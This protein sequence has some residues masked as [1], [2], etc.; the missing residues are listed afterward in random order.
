MTQAVP[1]REY[2]EQRQADEALDRARGHVQELRRQWEQGG[3][4]GDALPLLDQLEADLNTLRPQH[5]GAFSAADG[6]PL[7]GDGTRVTGAQAQQYQS[8]IEPGSMASQPL[9]VGEGGTAYPVADQPITERGEEV[10]A[11]QQQRAEDGET[12][13]Q[14]AAR[15]SA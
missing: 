8:R 15:M 7:Y 1:D 13:E 14:R 10:A 3:R 5:I 2:S 6:T 4:F 12:A 11:V 9:A